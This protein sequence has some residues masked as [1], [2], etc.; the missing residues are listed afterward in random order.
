MN[1]TTGPGESP[2]WGTAIKLV[3]ALSMAAI[4]IA[5][6]MRFRSLI[7][8]L[9]LVF[10]FSYLFHPIASWLQHKIHLPWPVAVTMLLILI[11]L[12]FFG[13][14][15][16]GGLAI[17]KQLQSFLVFIQGTVSNLPETIAQITSKSYTIGTFTFDFTQFDQTQLI[18]SVIGAVEPV[19]TKIGSALTVV[20]GGAAEVIGWF[21]FIL[22]VSYFILLE[23]KGLE[24][25]LFTMDLPGYA[26]DF[27][28]FG[29]ELGKIWNAFLR[30]QIIIILI[31]IAVYLVLLST[32]G[33]R[34]A[35]GLAVL[36]GMARFVPY[37]GP[38]IAW[39]TLGL[40][41]YFQTSNYFNLS[42]ILICGS[43]SGSCL[44]HGYDSGQFCRHSHAR[45][46]T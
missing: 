5:L 43:D 18:N 44:V 3:V 10:V 42:P 17:F 45:Q 6:I 41:S 30:G 37:A 22:L 1:P 38:A 34:F 36:A 27:T 8:P 25:Q 46:D 39:T 40:V 11:L 33:V 20:A 21:A 35:I 19:L 7:G 32:L 14:L 16:W 13:L 24:G 23:S 15:T 28:R 9:L 4:L 29:T 31:T 2:R 26:E 12:I